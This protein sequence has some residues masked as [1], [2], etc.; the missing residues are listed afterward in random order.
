MAKKTAT[1]I[2]EVWNWLI[3]VL[4]GGELTATEQAALVHVIARI[5]RNM[6][7]PTKINPKLIA[8]AIDKD[9]RT[10]KT[11]LSKIVS[12]NILTEEE[13][14]YYLGNIK[15]NPIPDSG[16]S[17]RNFQFKNQHD[18]SSDVANRNTSDDD[19]TAGARPN[20][21]GDGNSEQAQPASKRRKLFNTNP[22]E[23]S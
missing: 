23:E 1:N 3:N 11:A 18:I 12:L 19:G 2:V 4:E 9:T 13:G 10:V 5:N 17:E 8:A 16:R 21:A 22:A 15:R 6:W 7:T 14:V 20:T